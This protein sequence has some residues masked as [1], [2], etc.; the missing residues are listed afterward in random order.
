MATTQQT[1]Q[2]ATD[3]VTEGQ[4]ALL[5][6]EKAR[7]RAL[8]QTAVRDQPD[9]VEAWLWLSGTH[10]ER[11]QIDYCLRQVLARDPDNPQALEGLAWLART[12][13]TATNTH[14]DRPASTDARIADAGVTTEGEEHA[15][16]RPAT[17]AYTRDALPVETTSSLAL[18]ESALHV[19]SV[20]A[21]IGLLRLLAAVRPGTLLLLRGSSGSLS[22]TRGLVIAAIAAALH[23]LALIVIWLMLGRTLSRRRNDRQGDLFDS[24]VRATTLLTPGYISGL[25]LVLVAASVNFSERRWLPIVV[26]VWALLL[27]ALALSLRRLRRLL[28]TMR[29]ARRQRGVHVAQILVPVLIAG[30]LGIGLAGLAMQALLRQ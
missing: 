29:V 6:G 30:I 8:L 25:A 27:G 18:V 15:S 21:M 4:Q 17:L 22:L 5:R 3:L 7:A 28:D 19:V 12:F 10:S 14:A 16:P 9:N 11:E 24:L 26:V 20:G 2:T 13:D 23:A 1:R